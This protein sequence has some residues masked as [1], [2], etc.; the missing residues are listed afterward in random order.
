VDAR[1]GAPP[2]GK[3]GERRIV[4][5]IGVATGDHNRRLGLIPRTPHPIPDG[6]VV[7]P[8]VVGHL[9]DNAEE[10]GLHIA[11]G[12]VEAEPLV[13]PVGSY[14]MPIEGQGLT[15]ERCEDHPGPA[16]IV[17]QE[18]CALAAT[19]ELI[20]P[21]AAD[22]LV[23]VG[24]QREK[25]PDIAVAID[26]EDH[27]VAILVRLDLHPD[28]VAGLVVATGIQGD[29]HPRR[30][31]AGGRQSEGEGS[32]DEGGEHGSS[33]RTGDRDYWTATKCIQIR[34]SAK[35]LSHNTLRLDPPAGCPIR[36]RK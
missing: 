3:A 32:G 34:A 8:A 35:S 25:D 7:E 17:G 31:G 20:A 24:V 27:E 4:E 13:V 1:G 15:R 29:E 11:G 26:P 16:P 14:R 2:A 9:P 18:G 23:E 22:E 36:V 19:T 33:R 10:L 12:I 6:V 28:L 21:P 5:R 30:L